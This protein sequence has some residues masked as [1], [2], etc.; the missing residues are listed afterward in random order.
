MA[1]VPR[2]PVLTFDAA[3]R[4]MAARGD[5]DDAD[6]DAAFSSRPRRARGAPGY[7]RS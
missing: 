4:E 5:P 7:G 1:A 2:P 6:A 3:M